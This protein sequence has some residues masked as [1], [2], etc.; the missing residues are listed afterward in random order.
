MMSDALGVALDGSRVATSQSTL[1]SAMDASERGMQ[2][3]RLSWLLPD[4]GT[5]AKLKQAEPNLIIYL[6]RGRSRVRRRL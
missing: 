4:C 6:V 5:L 3:E 2:V 1:Q